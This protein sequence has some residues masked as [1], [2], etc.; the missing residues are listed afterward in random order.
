MNF[1]AGPEFDVSSATRDGRLLYWLRQNEQLLEV[2][3]DRYF[4]WL[5]LD[6]TVQ[7][8]LPLHHGGELCLPHQQL[9]QTLMP[10]VACQIL[11]LGLG[12]GDCLRWLHHRYPGA[13]Q[14]AVDL[15]ANIIDI[16]QRFFRQEEQPR[17]HCQ[18]ALAW[19]I[20]DQQQYD[21][22]LLDLFSDDGNPPLLF[23]RTTYHYLHQR[24]S[25][26]G[27]IFVNLLPRTEQELLQVHALL[28]DCGKVYSQ[29]ILH[30][31]NYLLWTEPA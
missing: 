28:N 31:R 15:N 8:V 21:L 26:Q 9:M 29:Q 30:Y 19:L 24:L 7:S 6:G 18:D 23:Q 2:R 10:A 4:R 20:D 17:L 27:R 1:S 13:E 22:I 11:H 25:P 16:Y 3:E 14:T 12:G 5:L